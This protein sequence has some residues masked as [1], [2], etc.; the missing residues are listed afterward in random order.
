MLG[1]M[2]DKDLSVYLNPKHKVFADTYLITGNASESAR[3]AGYS[4]NSAGISGHK[5][6]KRPDVQAYLAQQGAKASEQAE[7]L[8]SRVIQELERVA[9]ANIADFITIGDDGK[10]EI[11]F[12]SASREQLAA[13]VQVKSK[14][15]RRFDKDGNHVGTD[16]E[17]AFVMADKMRGLDGLARHLGIY[18]ETEQRVVVD[19]ADRLLLGRARLRAL[20]ADRGASGDDEGGRGSGGMRASGGGGGA[21]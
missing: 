9:F 6:L 2:S 12:S 17:H 15:S 21:P 14:S 11:D 10:P 1:R 20:G 8:Q 19:V 3:K 4:E 18:K 13:I 16:N 5:L 7:D